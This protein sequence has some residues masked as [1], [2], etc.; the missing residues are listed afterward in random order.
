MQSMCPFTVNYEG[1]M[2][3]VDKKPLVDGASVLIW[4]SL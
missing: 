2:C 4:S 3:K 1:L